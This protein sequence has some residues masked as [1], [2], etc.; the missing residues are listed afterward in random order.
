MVC[1]FVVRTR[2]ALRLHWPACGRRSRWIEAS[3][4]LSSSSVFSSAGCARQGRSA[5]LPVWWHGAI[6]LAWAGFARLV[7]RQGLPAWRH[8]PSQLSR[9]HCAASYCDTFQPF[10]TASPG[11][12][13]HLLVCC[14]DYVLALA[15]FASFHLCW[16]SAS[17]G[18][19]CYCDG[20]SIGGGTSWL[21]GASTRLRLSSTAP[22]RLWPCRICV[23]L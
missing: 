8:V 2:G 13:L 21:S 10:R 15:G 22:V 3:T 11:S 6:V 9:R 17:C 4:S 19:E 14:V 18:S 1:R 5:G 20:G 23:T 7:V 16:L 12:Y